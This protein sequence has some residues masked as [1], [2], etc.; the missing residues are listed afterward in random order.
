M[1]A[2]ESIHAR[3]LFALA[4]HAIGGMRLA[5]AAE[6]IGESSPTTLR[7]LQRLADDGLA[8]QM[9][10]ANKC[11]RLAPR[12]VQIALAH[13]AEMHRAQQS[14]DEIKNRY[15]RLPG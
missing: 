15:S 8:E 14:I 3:L 5:Q 7:A 10:D 13:Q 4:G 11:W 1:I 6:A 12:I 2:H 9:A